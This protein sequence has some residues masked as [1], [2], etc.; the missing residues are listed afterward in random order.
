MKIKKYITKY[1]DNIRCKIRFGQE[2]VSKWWSINKYGSEERAIN[3]A[4]RWRNAQLK[5]H[6]QL[7]RLKYKKNP[8]LYK[9]AKHPIIGVYFT[10]HKQQ[11]GTIS[12]NWT[13]R[14]SI[15]NKEVK[16]HYSIIKYGYKEAFLLACEFRYKHVGTL[17]VIN[18]KTLPC[19]PTVPHIN[20]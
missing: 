9:N 10:Y 20:L 6:N 2:T 18:K 5:K 12:T 4:T 3:L 15:K 13:A 19:V 1:D 17:R 8:D 14:V 7:F 16:K 11:N